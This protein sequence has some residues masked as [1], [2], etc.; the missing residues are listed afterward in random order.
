MSVDVGLRRLSMDSAAISAASAD[1]A[2]PRTS[3]D[4]SLQRLGCSN[5]ANRVDALLNELAMTI[6]RW[7]ALHDDKHNL[8]R[9][10]H[11]VLRAMDDFDTGDQ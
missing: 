11:D 1:S 10:L 5:V 6:N 7:L 2:K 3:V 8:R 9:L 4:R